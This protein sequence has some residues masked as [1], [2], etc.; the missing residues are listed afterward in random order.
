MRLYQ[1]AGRHRDAATVMLEALRLYGVTLPDLDEEIQ[2][3][4]EAEIRQVPINLRGRRIADLVDAPVAT[5]ESVRALIGLVAE[6]SPLIY[7]V[8]PAL[9]ALLTAKGVNVS[10][11][12]GHAEE[13]S[14]VYSCYSMVVVSILDDI[15]CAFQFSEMALR[16]NERFKSVTTKLKGK[17]LFHHAGVVNFWRR[18]YATSLPLMD[19]AFLDCLDVGDLI[20]AG[21]LTYNMVW[22][23]LENGDPLDRVIDVARKY[24]AFAR[25]THNE[26]VYHVVRLEEQFAA[27]LKGATQAATSFCDGAFD[28]ENSIAILNKAGFGLG[29]AVVHIMKQIAAF[30]HERYAEALESAASAALMQHQVA[31]LAMEAAHH[32]YHALTLTALHAQAP[33]EQRRQ[34]AQPLEEQLRKLKLW[35]D[36]CPENFQSRYALVSAEVARIEGRDLDGMRLYEEAIRSARDSGFVHNEALAYELASRFYRARGFERIA[37]TYLR[38]ARS[39]YVRWGA[40][41]KVKQLETLYPQLLEQRPLAPTATFAAR[42]EHLDLLSVVKASQTISSEILLEKLLRTLLEFVLEQGGA[43][44]GCLILVRGSDLTIEAEAAI[45]ER[46][47]TVTK[48][49]HSL[50]VSSSPL[51]PAS[52]LRYVRLTKERVLLD[53]AATKAGRFS[54]DEH[55]VRQKPRSI[56]CVPILRQAEV[57]GLLYLENNLTTHAFTPERL[58]ALELLAT[59]AAISLEHALLLARERGA[60]AAAEAAERRTAILAHELK[61]PLTGVHLKLDALSRSIKHQETVSS[62]WLSSSLT[63]LKGQ[64]GRLS[65]LI[66]SLLDLSRVQVGRLVL[67]REPVDL[68]ALVRDVVGRLSEQAALAGC[69]LHVQAICAVWG[70][71]DRLRLEQ[72]A[73]NLLTNALKYGAGKPVRIVADADGSVARLSIFDQGIGIS[74]PDQRRVFEAFER[75]TGLHQAQSLGL[76]LYLV[77]EIVR[78][79]GGRVHLHSQLGSGTTFT[80][81]LPIEPDGEISLAQPS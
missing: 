6:S 49:L 42:A 36:N 15:P 10:L 75:A 52:L 58:L 47:G 53:D 13:S 51:V 54:D 14:F 76:G 16:L 67:T 61:T 44:K 33:Q 12:C 55:I 69:A 38:E 46:Q 21:Y 34:F 20:C 81:E 24:T 73:T 72:V 62:S 66:D 77:R 45:E 78:A 65:V 70:Q 1:M 40:D 57:I 9:W 22:L 50:P 74:E 79:H 37:D 17:L 30:T 27:S 8:R 11:R 39:C 29:I 48:V 31:S 32:F 28:K 26:V 80:V 68:T 3:A 5:D 41:G 19:Q 7:S 63:S 59:Q 2:A 56:L 64:L 35:A 18:H 25:Q 23:L 43:Q 71:W 60:R 4:V